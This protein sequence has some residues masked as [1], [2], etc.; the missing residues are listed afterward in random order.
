MYVGCISNRRWK[1]LGAP[2]ALGWKLGAESSAL[3]LIVL[4]AATSTTK[5]VWL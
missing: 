1:R 2:A 4:S 5:K 3:I